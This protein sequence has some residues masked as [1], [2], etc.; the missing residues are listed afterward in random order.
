MDVLHE[1]IVERYVFDQTVR[2][3]GLLERWDSGMI[4]QKIIALKCELQFV[5][6]LFGLQYIV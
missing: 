4:F 5:V 2:Y 1:G 6:S 3:A